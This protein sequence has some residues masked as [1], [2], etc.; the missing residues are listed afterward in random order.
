MPFFPKD[1]PLMVKHEVRRNCVAPWSASTSE[2]DPREQ[3]RVLLNLLHE[4]LFHG[5]TFSFE[6]SSCTDTSWPIFPWY[7]SLTWSVFGSCFVFF[8]LLF[9]CEA[10]L[11]T[12][13]H[14]DKWL[15]ENNSLIPIMNDPPIN[16]V[17]MKHFKCIIPPRKKIMHLLI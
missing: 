8:A 4:D 5:L 1:I 14:C 2:Y 9:Y 7:F 11:L 12:W 3:T 15:Q 13:F 17:C 10:E 6:G 16:C